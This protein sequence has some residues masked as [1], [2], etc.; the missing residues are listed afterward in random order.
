LF[1]VA[2][3]GSKN[4][5]GLGLVIVGAA[6]LVIAC[7]L[8]FD[9]PTGPFRMVSQNTLVQMGDWWLIGL[10]LA[11]AGTG[12]RAYQYNR[13]EWVLPLIFSI[14]GAL[15][16]IAF[17]NDKDMRTL[18]PMHPN[19]TLD[20]SNPGTLV[21]LGVAIYVAGAG[22]AAAFI[23]SLALTQSPQQTLVSSG[24]PGSAETGNQEVSRLRRD[25]PRRRQSVQALWVPL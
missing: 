22:L 13:A 1:A 21:S 15:I 6:A 24:A 11:I 4:A 8:P 5:W 25:D 23:G 10:A 3:P 12:Y 20:T 14:I 16:I 9:E 17:A 7:F 19:G 18:Y 2:K